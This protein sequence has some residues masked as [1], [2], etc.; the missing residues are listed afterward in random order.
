M[1]SLPVCGRFRTKGSNQFQGSSSSNKSRNLHQTLERFEHLK[2]SHDL[3]PFGSREVL[4]HLAAF[5]A[6]SILQLLQLLQLFLFHRAEIAPR[7]SHQG[8]RSSS[9][10]TYFTQYLPSCSVSSLQS[11]SKSFSNSGWAQ[12]EVDMVYL[13]A[14]Q[15]CV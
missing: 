14:S 13:E 3:H 10:A 15:P 6:C 7:E 9:V 1:C 5:G 4:E 2:Q 11:W 8:R 12:I